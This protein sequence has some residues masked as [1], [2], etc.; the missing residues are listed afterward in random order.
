MPQ[1]DTI[2]RPLIIPYENLIH[3]NDFLLPCNIPTQT[4]KP[5]AVIKHLASSPLDD[6]EKTYYT[7]LPNQIHSFN[8]LLFVSDKVISFMVQ[9]ENKTVHKPPPINHKA[10]TR[11]FQNTSDELDT[12]LNNRTLQDLSQM[13]DACK[14]NSS[15]SPTTTLTHFITCYIRTNKLLQTLDLNSQRTT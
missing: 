9:A 10:P 5:L 12:M 4:V 8:E 3:F 15:D 14:R 2:S 7:A 1:K 13:L 11:F 6:K